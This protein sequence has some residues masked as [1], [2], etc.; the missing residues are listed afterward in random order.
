MADA[1][2]LSL[3]VAIAVWSTLAETGG[4]TLQETALH[5][6]IALAVAMGAASLGLGWT[7][8]CAAGALASVCVAIARID[9]RTFIIPDVLVATVA[10]LA[11]ARQPFADAALGASALGG[12]FA[13]VR[14]SHAAFRKTEGLGLG[15]VKLAAAMGAYLG[16]NAA[17]W[18]VTLA[19]VCTG[20]WLVAA[21]RGGAIRSPAPFGVGLAASLLAISMVVIP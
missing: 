6:G 11:L 17:L 13:A 5:G 7:A 2:L 19:A 10:V 21:A 3:A 14:G 12:M 20:L 1:L 18:A 9:R 8:A 16:L 4:S 15:D